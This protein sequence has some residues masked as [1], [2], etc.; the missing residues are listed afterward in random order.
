[1]KAPPGSPAG[2]LFWSDGKDEKNVMFLHLRVLERGVFSGAMNAK[3][4]FGIMC[5]FGAV[6]TSAIAANG[7][8][9]EETAAATIAGYSVSFSGGG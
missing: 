8:A 2:L 7:A 5:A 6:T 9:V 1:M 4:R 3:I